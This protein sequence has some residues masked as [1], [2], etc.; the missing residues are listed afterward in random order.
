MYR[1]TIFNVV[2]GKIKEKTL[3]CICKKTQSLIRTLSSKA[4]PFIILISAKR[5]IEFLT[6]NQNLN[7]SLDNNI[8]ITNHFD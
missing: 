3:N 6:F 7:V 8:F 1:I 4:V 5:I 2:L